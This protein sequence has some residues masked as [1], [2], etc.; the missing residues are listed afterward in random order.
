MRRSKSVHTNLTGKNSRDRG[1]RQASCDASHTEKK[2]TIIISGLSLMVMDSTFVIES[3][4]TDELSLSDAG[5]AVDEKR[6][7]DLSMFRALFPGARY[8]IDST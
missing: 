8:S 1:V 2:A 4:A 5:L 6:R 7:L 3:W